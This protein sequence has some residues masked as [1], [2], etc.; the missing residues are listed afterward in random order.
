[1]AIGSNG[2][3]STSITQPLPFSAYSSRY[4]QDSPIIP[5]H[6]LTWI[7]E[8]RNTIYR[9]LL[10]PRSGYHLDPVLRI[11]HEGR[12]HLAIL[13]TNQQIYSEAVS[14]LYSELKLII[15]A[16]EILYN[17][18]FPPASPYNRREKEIWR[19]N[20]LQYRN[21]VNADGRRIYKTSELDGTM[22]PHILGRF[23]NLAFNVI[24][25]HNAW[26][27]PLAVFIQHARNITLGLSTS[28]FPMELF[29][30]LKQLL[31]NA[32][33]L[34]TLSLHI[35]VAF[36]MGYPYLD[37]ELESASEEAENDYVQAVFEK[38]TDIFLGTGAEF[39]TLRT[40]SNL[41]NFDIDVSVHADWERKYDVQLP[42]HMQI[43]REL[44]HDIEDN[45]RR[46]RAFT[47][48]V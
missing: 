38:V 26:N 33:Y 23:E 4:G 31:S 48:G 43:L 10:V 9:I 1:M 42:K 30:G 2:V 25:E 15:D 44:K 6:W 16:G 11:K 12:I 45:F 32:P 14:I 17:Q 3:C 28:I 24:F 18:P 39:K 8:I 21:I 37:F 47:R 5:D 13:Q 20:P 29:D 35:D 19:R 34:N 36:S 27:E 7:A 46:K 41:E 22:E 40:I